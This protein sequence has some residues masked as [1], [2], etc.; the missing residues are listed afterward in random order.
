MLNLVLTKLMHIRL[1]ICYLVNKLNA[2]SANLDKISLLNIEKNNSSN[3]ILAGMYKHMDH[4]NFINNVFY[5]M[6]TYML[7]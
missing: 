7:T 3:N 5:R 6:H 4:I 2:L 1:Y